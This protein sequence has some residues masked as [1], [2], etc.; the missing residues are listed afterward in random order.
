MEIIQGSSYVEPG[1]NSDGGEGITISGT[2]DP[3]VPGTYTITYTSTDK[4][5]NVGTATRDVIV[6]ADNTAPVL[7]LTGE[8]PMEISQGG[9]YVEPGCSTDGGE[10]CTITGTVNPDVP[11]TY[12]LTY[13]AVDEA[14]N[15]G[16]A[17]R[18]VIVTDNIA[19]VLTLN[20]ETPMEISQG[21]SY[22]E[23]GASTN[24]GEE[25]TITGV[26]NPNVPG[27]YTITYTAVDEAG[28]IG[29][30]TRD[31]IVTA[32]NTAPVLTLTGESPM[33][34]S[35]GGSYVEPGC[36]SDGGEECTVTG[37]VNPNK[38]GTYTLT[39]TSVDEAGNVG[40]ATREVIVHAACNNVPTQHCS[41]H[42]DWAYNTG[43]NTD[44][45]MYPEFEVV[46]G[47]SV[48]NAAYADMQLYFYC[49]NTH[50]C[51]DYG[52]LPPCCGEEI[53][54]CQ[55]ATAPVLTLNGER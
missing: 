39:Y 51:A 12:T 38:P 30:A 34:I 48:A 9:S 3:N 36:S 10:E 26:V 47:R 44:P 21:G 7:T 40:T 25:V 1:C 8:S 49:K 45:S 20:G 6:I 31:V 22:T 28:N 14:G 15:V 29:T 50:S 13:T 41:G 24:G 5:G 17:T 11:G 4:A 35:Q 32:D 54:P 55:D 43:R 52:L 53:C 37:T 23:L 16:T 2:V 27:T 18:E 19:P 33:E 42:I 46:T